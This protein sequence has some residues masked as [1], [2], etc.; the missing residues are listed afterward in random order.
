MGGRAVITEKLTVKGLAQGLHE[1]EHKAL[2]RVLKILGEERCVE[3][4]AQ[5]LTVEHEGGMRRKDDR[6]RKRTLGGVF[7]ALCRQ[8]ATPAER[9]AMFR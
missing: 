1:T 7:L 2:A 8:Q 9:R 4:L 5:A 6:R 3:L